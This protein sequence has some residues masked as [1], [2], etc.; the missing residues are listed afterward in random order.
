MASIVHPYI[1]FASTHELRIAACSGFPAGFLPLAISHPHS[2]T[3]YIPLLP[4]CNYIDVTTWLL[5]LA[6]FWRYTP[7]FRYS[8]LSSTLGLDHTYP[9]VINVYNI[10]TMC[11]RF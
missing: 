3:S 4:R 11:V 7:F 9:F 10:G 5:A 6:L 1:L 8:V 2:C